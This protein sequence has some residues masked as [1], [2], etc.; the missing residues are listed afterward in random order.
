MTENDTTRNALSN[1]KKKASL[2]SSLIPSTFFYS[3]PFCPASPSILILLV[4]LFTLP[5]STG[6]KG[7]LN[8]NTGCPRK[9]LPS[10][11]LLRLANQK[12]RARKRADRKKQVILAKGE[13]RLKSGS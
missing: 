9:P 4:L 11:S 5:S 2:L 13:R 6:I 12:H 1:E 3:M 7:T 10:A 8:L